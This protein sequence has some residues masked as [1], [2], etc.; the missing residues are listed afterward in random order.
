MEQIRRDSKN[1]AF[2]KDFGKTRDGQISTF[3]PI[4][5]YHVMVSISGDQN[6][7]VYQNMRR[8]IPTVPDVF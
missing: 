2:N 8:R 7:P 3:F 4:V 6:M 5:V 1:R